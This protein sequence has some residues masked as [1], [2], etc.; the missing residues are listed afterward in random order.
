MLAEFRLQGGD[1]WVKTR[2]S[3]RATLPTVL[4]FGC[5]VM[6]ATLAGHCTIITR[7]F[8]Q[9]RELMIRDDTIG[10]VQR[11]QKTLF[12]PDQREVFGQDDLCVIARGTS[13]QVSNNPLGCM[14]YQAIFVGLQPELISRFYQYYP[15]HAATMPITLSQKLTFDADLRQ[16]FLAL[17]DLL[18]APISSARQELRLLELLLLLAERGVCFALPQALGMSDLIRRLVGSRLDQ[19]WSVEQ[20]AQGLHVST[21]TLQRRLSEEQVQLRQLLQDLRLEQ[22]LG[23]LQTSTLPIGEI[24]A[25]CGYQSHSRF[26]AAFRERFGFIPSILRPSERA[27]IGAI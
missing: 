26:S 24:A 1:R 2:Q 10:Y 12:H 17:P 5:V 16:S 21:R 14:H 6:V 11:G 22:G 7:Q 27:T 8:H 3:V 15:S 13:W 4:I 23:L 19:T 20:I 18:T 9:I 25:R